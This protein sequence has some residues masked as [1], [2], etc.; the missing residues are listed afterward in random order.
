M[1]AE[2]S[3][4]MVPATKDDL[5]LIARSLAKA[6]ADDPVMSVLFNGSVPEPKATRFFEIMGSIQLKHEHIYRTP[7]SEA[8]AIWAPPGEW[9]VP[10]KDIVRMSPGLIKVFGR[11]LIPN[12]KI[13]DTMEKNHPTDLHY[14]LEFIGTDPAHQG[15]GL[16]TG[17]DATDGRPL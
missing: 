13:L 16:G 1:D 12:L 5:P 15:K 8:A 11:R 14:Y 7:G 4:T 3:S 6:F 9:K 10:P 17:V 2:Q